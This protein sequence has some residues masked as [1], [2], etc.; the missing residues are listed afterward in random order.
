MSK[1]F[2][3]L[4]AASILTFG[5]VASD[6]KIRVV[7]LAPSLT[8]TVCALGRADAL[9]GRTSVDNYP[10]EVK[11]IP[12]VGNF[13]IPSLEKLITVKPTLVIAADF[14][15]PAIIQTLEGMNIKVMTLPTDSISDY[16]NAVAKLGKLLDCQKEADKEIARI[17]KGLKD[18]KRQA[19]RTP[20]NKRPRVFMEIWNDPI[21]TVGNNS[22]LNDFIAYA[23]GENIA[24]NQDKAYFNCSEEWII[25]SAPQVIICPSMGQGLIAELEKKTG[26]SNIPAVKEKRIYANL[27]QDIIFRLGPRLLEG[28]ESIKDCIYPPNK[29]Q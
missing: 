16:L 9:V 23:G 15:D 1:L 13:G 4:F 14:K 25:T 2:L 26:W 19:D 7:S 24:Q 27:N 20:K 8:E 22:F 10:P 5:A 29:K 12:I 28:I 3:F 11:K 17:K 6:K 18:F 21:M